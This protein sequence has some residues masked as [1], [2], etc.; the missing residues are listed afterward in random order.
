MTIFRLLQ[1]LASFAALRIDAFSYRQIHTSKPTPTN[2]QYVRFESRRMSHRSDSNS[3]EREDTTRHDDSVSRR[4]LLH[5]A[6]LLF[7]GTLSSG[8]LA[9]LGRFT[10]TDPNVANK[11]LGDVNAANA[12]GLVQFPCQ[13]GELTNTYHM[14]RAGESGLE[15]EGILSTNPLFL[16]NREDALTDLG[17]MQVE[18]VGSCLSFSMM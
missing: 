5:S 15:A 16:T 2:F 1:L 12:M 11:K 6:G 8:P 13:P 9:S 17:T 3:D 7:A 18:E 14:M 10:Y 4:S